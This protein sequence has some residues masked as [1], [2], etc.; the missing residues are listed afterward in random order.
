MKKQLY[1]L[2][3]SFIALL[4]LSNCSTNTKSNK[5][6]T[7]GSNLKVIKDVDIY[8]M[9]IIEDIDPGRVFFHLSLS[10]TLPLDADKEIL[11]ANLTQKKYTLTDKERKLFMKMAGIGED[12][13]FWIYDYTD[14]QLYSYPISSLEATA[15]LDVYSSPPYNTRDYRI[16]FE[17]PQDLLPRIDSSYDLLVSITKDNPF[18][19]KQLTPLDWRL[20]PNANYPDTGPDKLSNRN[21]GNVP[22]YLK[23]Y[24]A[25]ANNM[26][27][28]VQDYVDEQHPQLLDIYKIFERELL[29]VDKEGKTLFKRRMYQSEGT[30]LVG[31][32]NYHDY[33]NQKF[34]WAG[35]LFKD[36]PPVVFGFEW[37]SFSC[38]GLD[39]IVPYR[40]GIALKCDNRH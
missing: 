30:S 4:L 31:L 37:F 3:M 27:F 23:S 16:G 2:L 14:N 25:N 17:L 21:Y 24:M 1:L 18:A 9:L 12:A 28:Y 36:L 33:E 39:F 7:S 19:Q 22:K 8:H 10:E 11:P 38:E 32:N 29:V 26:T 40:D 15:I 35:Q 34:Q 5:S 6:E 13:Y 20:I